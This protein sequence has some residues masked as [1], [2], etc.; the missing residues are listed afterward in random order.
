MSNQQKL[1]RYCQGAVETAHIDDSNDVNPS[2]IQCDMGWGY[3]ANLSRYYV[4]KPDYC[5]IAKQ[6]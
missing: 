1:H 2:E 5:R 4:M 6:Y 3:A